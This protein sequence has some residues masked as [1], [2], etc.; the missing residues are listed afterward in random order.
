MPAVDTDKIE[1][2]VRAFAGAT[3]YEIEAALRIEAGRLR[4]EVDQPALDPERFHAVLRKGSME[5]MLACVD[6]NLGKQ[7]DCQCSAVALEHAA[8]ALKA[9]LHDTEPLR[10]KR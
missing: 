1:A 9:S 4:R 6:A 8:E 10:R 2:V 3:A 7:L 5:E